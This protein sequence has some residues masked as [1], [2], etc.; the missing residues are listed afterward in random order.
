MV[1][2]GR[3][4][5]TNAKPRKRFRLARNLLPILAV[6]AILHWWRSEPLPS[7]SFPPLAGNLVGADRFDLGKLKNQPVLVHFW[8]TWCPVC[9]L[10]DDAIQA[11]AKDFDVITVAIQSG[12]ATEIAEHLHKEGLSFPVIADPY[13]EIANRWGVSGVP[14]S[15]VLDGTGRIRFAT[16]GY[17]T[18]IGLRGRL[19][20]A[21]KI[22]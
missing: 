22:E 17:T 10:G 13:G 7:G 12:G 6:L 9:R 8:A 3:N 21:G 1:Q 4:T 19:W 16:A 11:I 20:A 5:N 15:F 18:E 14:T 2:G